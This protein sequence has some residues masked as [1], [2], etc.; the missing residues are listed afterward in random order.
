MSKFKNTKIDILVD[1]DGTVVGHEYP[2]IGNDVGAVPI[3]KQLVN[4]GHRLILFTMRSNRPYNYNDGSIGFNGLDEAVKWYSDNGIKL[5]GIQTN[6]EQKSWTDSP[7]AYGQFI[8]DDTA[9]FAPLKT[10]R[11]VS[12][13]PFIDWDLMKEELLRIGLIR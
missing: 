7:K 10:D 6:P 12:N 13:R 3:L 9:A 2:R 1:F 4:N 11:L 8:I 5:F